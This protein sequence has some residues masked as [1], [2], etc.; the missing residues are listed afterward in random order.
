MD[1]LEAQLEAA[2]EARVAAAAEL[3][4]A[5]RDLMATRLAAM[6]K[7]TRLAEEQ[8]K[9]GKAPLPDKAAHP[10]LSCRWERLPSQ[11]RQP[12]LLFL[13]GGRERLGRRL[14]SRREN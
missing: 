14:R 6:E 10:S 13:A 3:T 9:A 2:A 5:R 12:T 4:G 1:S 11:I 7:K 8:E